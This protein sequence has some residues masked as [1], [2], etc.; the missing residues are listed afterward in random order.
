MKRRIVNTNIRFQMDREDDLR[1]WT[2][3]QNM[4]RTRYKSYTRAVVAAV[5]DYFDRQGK[6]ETDPFLESRER[7]DAFLQRM[8]ETLERSLGPI[9]PLAAILQGGIVQNNA[10]Q[11]S[12]L[13]HDGHENQEMEKMALDF[14]ESL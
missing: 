5:N 2:H 13:S 14:V 7:E 9:L 4:D 1:A 8:V 11:P 10:A 12:I 6:L 3:L